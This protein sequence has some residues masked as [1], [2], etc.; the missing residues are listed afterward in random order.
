MRYV[1]GIRPSGSIH[2]GNYLGAIKHAKQLQCR[3]FV[4]DLH[5]IH[6]REEVMRTAKLLVDLGLDVD[7]QSHFGKE[8]L[9]LYAD[10]LHYATIG[11]L[12]RMTQYKEKSEKEAQT[13]ALLT[14]PVLMA[15]DIFH[16]RGSHIP[17][18]N[19]QVQHIEFIRDLYDKLPDAA[20]PKPQAVISEYPRIMSLKDGTKKMSKS[21][22]DDDTR[23]NLTDGPEVIHRK[24]MGAK[25]ALDM[26]DDTPEMRN[27]K[28]IYKAVGGTGRHERFKDFKMELA[29]LIISELRPVEVL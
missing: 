1:T 23:I 8:H 22:P 27:L 10:L 14:Y 2:F 28:T 18:G 21:D 29:T 15:A 7:I 6:D 3:V 16:L 5:G 24:I 11:H 4:A 19:D 17:V 25:T 20:F 12:S 9:R 26:A 13:A